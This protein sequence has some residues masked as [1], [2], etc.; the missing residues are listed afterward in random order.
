MKA[1]LTLAAVESPPAIYLPL[2]AED[3]L[4]E[5]N[6]KPAAVLGITTQGAYVTGSIR[7]TVKHLRTQAGALALWRGWNANMFYVLA[8][9]ALRTILTGVFG[10]FLPMAIA[11][12]V[13]GVLGFVALTRFAMTCTQ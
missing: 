7:G 13:A 6:R 12:P 2:G 3:L 9:A 11:R 5:R 8:V 10:S 4:N 1:I